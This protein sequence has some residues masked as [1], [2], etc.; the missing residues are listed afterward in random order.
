MTSLSGSYSVG[1]LIPAPAGECWQVVR[2]QAQSDGL[3][4]LMLRSVLNGADRCCGE[5]DIRGSHISPIRR[6]LARS[7]RART[8]GGKVTPSKA[9]WWPCPN[10]PIAPTERSTADDGAGRPLRAARQGRRR[11]MSVVWRARDRELDREVAIK[12]LRSLVAPDPAPVAPLPPRSARACG[13]R[14]RAHRSHL[15]LH[16]ERRAVVPGHGVRRRCQPRADD[17]WPAPARDRRGR[18]LHETGRAGARLRTRKRSC[19]P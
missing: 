7:L 16:I 8:A 5:G 14:A 3:A 18:R 11:G 12:M 17:A 6:V 4:G 1:D 19:A 10:L 15:R 13:A 9:G 2:C